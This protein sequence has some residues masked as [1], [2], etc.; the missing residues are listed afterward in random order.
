MAETAPTTATNAGGCRLQSASAGFGFGDRLV[1]ID[2]DPDFRAELTRL[3]QSFGIGVIQLNTSDPLDSTLLLAAREK[4]EINWK[5]VDR[6][7][8]LNPDFKEFV[9]SVA[10]SVKINQPAINGFDKLLTD[11]ELDVR[12]KK[13]LGK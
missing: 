12:L 4:S 11:A 7:A 5:T 6:I 10:K 8:A 3:S 2:D 13:M 1:D 9:N